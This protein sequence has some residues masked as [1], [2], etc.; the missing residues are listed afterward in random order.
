MGR[1]HDRRRAVR[2]FLT[3][4]LIALASCEHAERALAPPAP[5]AV[6][7]PP[8]GSAAAGAINRPCPEEGSCDPPAVCVRY[9]GVAGVQ[10]PELS[11]CEIKC[12]ADADCPA[13]LRCVTIADGPGSVCRGAGVP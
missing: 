11:S 10:G 1:A 13:A 5:Q 7:R 3:G 9:Y 6:V 2:M 8:P 4:I 12:G